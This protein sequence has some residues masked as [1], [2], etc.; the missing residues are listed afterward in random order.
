MHGS[1]DVKTVA[2]ELLGRLGQLLMHKIGRKLARDSEQTWPSVCIAQRVEARLH[3]IELPSAS[4]A[5]RLQSA[6]FGQL[7]HPLRGGI[8]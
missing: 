7:S 5:A 3:A 1:I 2:I 6:W 8:I 4:G